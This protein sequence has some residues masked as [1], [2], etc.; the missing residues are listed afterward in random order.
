MITFPIYLDN[1]AT[2]PVDPQVL[3]AMLPFFREKYGNPSSRNHTFGW[4]AEEAVENARRQV[5]QLINAEPREIIFTSGATESD[6]L[7]LKGAALARRDRGR[8]IISVAT[9]HKAV[10]ETCDSLRDQGFDITLAPVGRDGLLDCD[11]LGRSIRPE[12]I[13][14]SVM[15]ANNEIGVL[16]PLTEIG[17]IA[18]KRGILFHTDAAQAAGRIQIDVESMSIDLLSLSAHKM[19]GPKGVGALYVRRNPPVQLARL[20]DGGGQERGLRS[21]TLNVPGIVGLGKACEV[22]RSL[23]DDEANRLTLFRDRMKARLLSELNDVFLNGHPNA[24]LPGN[25]NLAF[26]Y[27]EGETLLMGLRDVALSSG[28][29]CTTASA[30]PSHVLKAIGLSSAMA[31]SSIRFGLGR[32]TTEEEVEWVTQ[33]VIDV[34]QQLRAVSPLYQMI[35]A[36]A[37]PVPDAWKYPF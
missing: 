5:A 13:L 30:D 16:Q 32:F 29:A 18:R 8:H 11:L 15:A 34:V 22:A 33:K 35:T 36:G 17:R 28:S 10:L 9:E 24:R 12:T 4:V 14:I 20:L 19:Y 25:L 3:D 37:M 6:N 2:T 7:A 21:G 26:S 31:A 27:V 1:H 23:M